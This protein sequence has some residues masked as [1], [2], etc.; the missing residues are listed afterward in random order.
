VHVPAKQKSPGVHSAS[1]VPQL[2]QLL[3]L[4]SAP[5][6]ETTEPAGHVLFT[7]SQ[8]LA[9]VDCGGGPLSQVGPAHCT[10]TPATASAGHTVEPPHVSCK[11]HGPF[12]AR[13]TVAAGDADAWLHALAKH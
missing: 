8:W 2:P 4:Q 5:L 9:S 1:F 3:P 10:P 12:C 11:S 7:E 13:H 6:H